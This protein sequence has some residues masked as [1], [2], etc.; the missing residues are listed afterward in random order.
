MLSLKNLSAWSVHEKTMARVR[1][2]RIPGTS[3]YVPKVKLSRLRSTLKGLQVEA[4]LVDIDEG[5]RKALKVTWQSSARRGWLKLIAYQYDE[6]RRDWTGGRSL[7][8][9]IQS[10]RRAS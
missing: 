1:M 2:T 10:K 4:R 3:F 7:H 5:T 9:L 8:D 6:V